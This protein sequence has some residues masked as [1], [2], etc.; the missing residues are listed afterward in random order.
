MLRVRR[1]VGSPSEV[2][3]VSHHYERLVVGI[4]G[5]RVGK[6]PGGSPK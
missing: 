6:A 3:S 1:M 4:G 5:R 2:L